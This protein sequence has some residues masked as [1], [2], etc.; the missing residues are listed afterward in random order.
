MVALHLNILLVMT[1]PSIF[2][3][4]YKLIFF[5]F[6]SF[7]FL[8]VFFLLLRFRLTCDVVKDIILLVSWDNSSNRSRGCFVKYSATSSSF[9]LSGLKLNFIKSK[10]SRREGEE[11]K[12]TVLLFCTIQRVALLHYRFCPLRESL[13]DVI[14]EYSHHICLCSNFYLLPIKEKERKRIN[15]YMLLKFDFVCWKTC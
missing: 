1:N 5:L 11:E 12:H 3:F 9:I 8:L 13:D 2:C 4:E 6:F 15:R 10:K 14:R 7:F